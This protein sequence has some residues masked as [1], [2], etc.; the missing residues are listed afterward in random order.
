MRPLCCFRVPLTSCFV[1]ILATLLA[2]E[3]RTL[4]QECLASDPVGRS[5]H[6][7]LLPPDE[8][9]PG[10]CGSFC[11]RLQNLFRSESAVSIEPTYVGEV[12]TNTRGGISTNNSTQYQGL[13]NLA[14]TFDMDALC[15]PL[16]GRFFL[17]AQNTHGRGLTED[18]VGDTQV[19]SNIDSF[20]NIAQVSEYWWEVG[21]LDGVLIFRL[22]K[23]D[24]NTEFLVMD[25]AGDFLNASFGISPSTGFS[26]YPNPSMAAVGLVQCAP[27]LKLKIGIWDA[28]SSGGNWGVSGNE[29]T[30][31]FGDRAIAPRCVVWETE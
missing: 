12:F 5:P 25:L 1:A 29:V 9:G 19:I 17:L 27:D 31:T 21:L 10:E 28:L 23:Q 13:I 8:D 16:P 11:S 30:F 7:L 4:G 24:L 14:I 22:G 20:N 18:F 6:R 3:Q 15:A 26:S 2:L